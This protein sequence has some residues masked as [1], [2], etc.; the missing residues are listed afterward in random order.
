[1]V[2]LSYK[3]NL[4]QVKGIELNILK[5]LDRV[6]KDN[7]LRYVLAYGSCLGAVRHEG[8]IPW[9]DDIDVYMPRSDYEKLFELSDA[10]CFEEPYKLVSY[11]DD[12]SIYPFAK[13]VDTNTRSIEQFTGGGYP[14]SVWLDI[15]PL[16]LVHQSDFEKCQRN[17][18][19][20]NAY[21]WLRSFRVADT[22]VGSTWYVKLVK[23]LICPLV[24]FLDLRELNRKM[25]DIA[26]SSGCLVEDEDTDQQYCIALLCPGEQPFKY[27]VLFPGTPRLFEDSLL[28]CPAK[29]EEYLEGVYG[30]WRELPK[31]EL[32]MAH[33]PEAYYVGH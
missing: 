27:D 13:V 3:L 24:S 22:T 6:C 29:S 2:L 4:Q 1:M 8:F 18:R 31:E 9:D 30:D 14:I 23:K 10:G 32:R 12:S 19:K 33:M 21:S 7:N 28:P 20:I 11:R 16:E 25:D 26:R 5:E 17:G 15:F